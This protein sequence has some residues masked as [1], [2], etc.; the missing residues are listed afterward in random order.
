MNV[1]LIDEEG[2]QI[3]ATLFKDIADKFSEQLIEEH[4]YVISGGVIK[5]V[6]GRFAQLK[7]E[8]CIVFDKFTTIEEIDDDGSVANKYGKGSFNFVTIAEIADLNPNDSVDIVGV[9]YAVGP[10]GTV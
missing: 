7:H 5:E 6:T 2:S 1:D 4:V 9:A 10:M 3:Q 8:F